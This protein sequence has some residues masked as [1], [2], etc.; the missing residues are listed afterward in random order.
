MLINNEVFTELTPEKVRE[1]LSV[2]I[3]KKKEG[4]SD[5]YRLST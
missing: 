2:F 5:D 1:I 3:N 4:G